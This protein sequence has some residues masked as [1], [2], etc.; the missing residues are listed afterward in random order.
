M[1]NGSY[2]ISREELRPFMNP[3]EMNSEEGLYLCWVT[4]PAAARRVLPP[5]FDL[6][7]PEHPLAMVYVVNIREP[8]FA[9]WYM[10][11]GLSL[12]CRY[13]ELAGVYFLSLQLSGPGAHMGLCSGREMA[14]LPKKMC[15]RIVVER[16]G[17]WAQAFIERKRRRIF[18]VQV[19]LG[20]CNDPLMS[21]MYRN[22]GP[23][24]R[25]RGAC[26][27]FQY[28]CGKAP[29][30]HLVLPRVRLV[31]YDSVTDYQ[32]WEPG[33]ITSLVMEPSL[34]DPW[35]EIP[36]VRL[37]GAGYSVNSNWVAGITTLTEYTGEEAD[38]L[39]SYLFTGRWDRSTLATGRHQ[40]YGQFE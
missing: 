22:H 30:G 36:V 6:L 2:F 32:S 18:S 4:D 23:G 38:S 8:T 13:R 29:E 15:E 5:Q 9:P 3:G 39:F 24:Y 12:L 33:R 1:G 31:H 28:D 27:L 17:D 37:L 10:E 34:D 21:E 16:T 35:A 20:P 25:D 7:D 19:E 40:C 14:G 26:L 11:G